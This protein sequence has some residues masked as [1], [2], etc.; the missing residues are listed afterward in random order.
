MKTATKN[1]MNSTIYERIGTIRIS[2][3]ERATAIAAMQEGEEIAQAVL[4]AAHV[5]RL[6]V[7]MPNLKPSLRH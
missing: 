7:S 5:L 1:S 3:A 4:N 6:L 2:A